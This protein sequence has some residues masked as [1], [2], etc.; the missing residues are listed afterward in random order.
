M[1]LGQWAREWIDSLGR[2]DGESPTDGVEREVVYMV[3][4]AVGT[5]V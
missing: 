5:V 1:C 2:E 3:V 4:S